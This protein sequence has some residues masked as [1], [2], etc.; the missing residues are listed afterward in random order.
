MP[1]IL[2]DVFLAVSTP[3]HVYNERESLFRISFQALDKT[4]CIARVSLQTLH[5]QDPLPAC[6]GDIVFG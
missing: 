3:A 1:N 6:P 4:Q 2:H 5:A